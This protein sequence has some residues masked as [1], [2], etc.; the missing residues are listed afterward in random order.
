[1][2]TPAWLSLMSVIAMSACA[3]GGAGGAT[4][5]TVYSEQHSKVFDDGADMLEDPGALE[6]QWSADWESEMDSRAA[7]SD[8]IAVVLVTTLRTD[9]APEGTTT[10]RIVGTSK[11]V[12]KGEVPS[13]GLSL[14][15]QEGAL[16]YGTVDS[17]KQKILNGEFIAFVKWFRSAEGTAEAHWHLANATPPVVARVKDLL[18]QSAPGHRT[19]IKVH[20][21]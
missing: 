10:Y 11:Q 20:K 13:D 3:S 4:A 9:V 6:G 17:Q 1:M 14:S 16:G 8:I 12:W 15:V 18:G 5:T 19:V 21:N 2:R 7:Q